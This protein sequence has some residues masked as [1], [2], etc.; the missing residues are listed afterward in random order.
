MLIAN[1]QRCLAKPA[2]RRN[3]AAPPLHCCR[4]QEAAEAFDAAANLASDSGGDL[5]LAIHR[6]A[7]SEAAVST[8]LT[9]RPAH[10]QYSALR[11]QSNHRQL[12]KEQLRTEL[13]HR[14]FCRLLSWRYAR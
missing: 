7:L 2:T 8:E 14:V 6:R 5:K 10:K 9:T 1:G 13:M 3:A 12:E 4:Y 11:V